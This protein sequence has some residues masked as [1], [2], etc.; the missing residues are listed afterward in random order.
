MVPHSYTALHIASRNG[1]T[2]VVDLLVK[3]GGD[4]EAEENTEDT[5]LIQAVWGGHMST[6]EV[7]L[8]KGADVN[9]KRKDK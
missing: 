1:H 3:A 6:I 2:E 9:H 4:I 5:P 8:S 7:L